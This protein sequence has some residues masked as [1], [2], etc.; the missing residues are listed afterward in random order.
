MRLLQDAPLSSFLSMC[1]SATK[2]LRFSIEDLWHQIEH[3]LLLRGPTEQLVG[4]NGLAARIG[5]WSMSACVLFPSI[6]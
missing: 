1:P 2:R 6:A 4:S 5:A 3:T